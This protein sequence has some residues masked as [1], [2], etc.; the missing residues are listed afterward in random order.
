MQDKSIFK[1]FKGVDNTYRI[2]DMIRAKVVVGQSKDLM[3]AFKRIANCDLFKIIK[4]VNRLEE[5]RQLLY[6]NV[7]Y[8]DRIICEIIIKIGS[9]PANYHTH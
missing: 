7:V 8:Y 6:I 9:K 2:Y 3:D 1:A 5:P 4:V